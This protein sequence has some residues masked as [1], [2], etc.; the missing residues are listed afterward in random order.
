MNKGVIDTL[1]VGAGPMGLLNAIGLLQQDSHRKVLL[2]EKREE[3]TRKHVVRFSAAKLTEF[4]EA[5]GAKGKKSIPE[6]VELEKRLHEN[7]AIRINELETILRKIALRMGAEIQYEEVEDVRGQIYDQYPMLERLIGC[8]GTHSTV[9]DQVFGI[10]N[11]IKNSYDYVLQVRFEVSGPSSVNKVDLPTWPTYLQ[12]YGL[13]GEEI[14]GKQAD[15]ITPITM[16]IMIPKEDFDALK[17]YATAKDPIKPFNEEETKLQHIPDGMMQKVKGYL[18]FRLAH[19]TKH[20]VGEQINMSDIRL[21]VNE[22]PATRA[23]HVVKYEEVN[24]R[25]ICIM[26]AGDAALGLSYFKGVNAGLENMSKALVALNT[27]SETERREKISNYAKWFD[28]DLA[29]RKIKEVANYSKYIARLTESITSFLNRLLGR[30]FLMNTAQAERYA[31]L[32]HLNQRDARTNPSN[33]PSL[34]SAYPHRKNYFITVLNSTPV[35]LSEYEKQIKN[36]FKKYFKTYKSNFYLYQDLL[37]P[38]NAMRHLLEGIAK[39]VFSPLAFIV[40]T[41]VN[42]AIFTY[43]VFINLST[44]AE[45]KMHWDEI[46]TNFKSA[47]T[48]MLD[49]LAEIGLGVVLAATSILLPIKLIVN[50][51]LTN[52]EEPRKIENNPGMVRLVEEADRIAVKDEFST[53]KMHALLIDA[54]R[55]FEKSLDRM[56]YTQVSKEAENKA[57]NECNLHEPESYKR[58]FNLFKTHDLEQTTQ[59]ASMDSGMKF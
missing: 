11:Q 37:Q 52:R 44:M 18:G 9:S 16:Q 53:N 33:P 5:I 12:A 48:R 36:H 26:L 21:S 23:K 50:S 43:T 17:P 40:F 10:E 39:I 57:Y 24:G 28:Q 3:Y 41:P 42:L 8:D 55:K 35:P 31:E 7:S 14:V 30:D 4:M 25:L 45:F 51:I 6:L 22:A 19:Y 38:L 56:Q 46:K 1:I 32:Y 2:L 27:E 49:G 15:G 54:H 47:A 58:Y 13:V 34:D 20:K 59:S 29:P